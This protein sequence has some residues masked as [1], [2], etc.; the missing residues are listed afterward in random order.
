MQLCSGF[1]VSVTELK[2]QLISAED[3]LHRS[4]KSP[5]LQIRV[6]GDLRYFPGRGRRNSIAKRACVNQEEFWREIV[7]SRIDKQI[8]AKAKNRGK[9][10][11]FRSD[12]WVVELSDPG[13]VRFKSDGSG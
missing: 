1:S 7:Q 12:I 6:R 10:F 9:R 4:A 13:G 5:D 2:R 8:V 11:H 3:I